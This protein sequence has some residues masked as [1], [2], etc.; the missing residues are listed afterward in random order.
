MFVYS[1]VVQALPRAGKLS[2]LSRSAE[3]ADPLKGNIRVKCSQSFPCTENGVSPSQY[4]QIVSR[5]KL[6]LQLSGNS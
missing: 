5:F 1:S 6:S 3:R 2:S 4:L